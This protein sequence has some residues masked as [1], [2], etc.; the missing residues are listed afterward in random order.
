[1]PTTTSDRTISELRKIF[2]VHGLPEQVVSDNGPQ[3]AS[4][5]FTHFLRL[6]GIRHIP[7]APYHPATSGEAERMVQTFKHAIKASRTDEGT[8]ETKLARFLI[9]YRTTPNTTTGCSLAQLLFNRPINTR[10]DMLRPSLQSTSR[11]HRKCIMTGTVNHGS[12]TCNRK[13]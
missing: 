2:A 6:N 10:L 9:S 12:L 8:L 4:H 7:S 1:M 5:E 13:S 11:P 3:F